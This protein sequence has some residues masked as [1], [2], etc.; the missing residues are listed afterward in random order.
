MRNNR[1]IVTFNES[2]RADIRNGEKQSLRVKKLC[3]AQEIV[4]HMNPDIVQEAI[5]Q[6]A[7]GKQTVIVEKPTSLFWFPSHRLMV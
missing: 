6:D 5:H 4:A 2:L 7:N 3:R 1:L